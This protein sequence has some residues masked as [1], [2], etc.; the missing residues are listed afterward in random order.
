[1]K[2]IFVVLCFTICCFS[3]LMVWANKADENLTPF[4]NTLE[5]LS[6][7]TREALK[8]NRDSV[9]Y[10]A[11]EQIRI[12]RTINNL[13]AIHQG[14]S[15]LS[16]NEELNGSFETAIAYGDTAINVARLIKIPDKLAA[17]YNNMGLMQRSIANYKE[18]LEYLNKAL[19]IKKEMGDPLS[20]AFTLNN[21]GLTYFTLE[22]YD[23][24]LIYLT[25][26]L[27]LKWKY[28]TPL[29]MASTLT[30]I[31]AVY[32]ETFELDKA[33]EFYNQSIPLYIQNNEQEGLANVLLNIGLIYKIKAEY[34][35]ALKYYEEALSIS[36]ERD[37]PILEAKAQMFK[38]SIFLEQKN[39]TEAKRLFTLARTIF[40]S[41]DYR[42]GMAKVY[43]N[44]ALVYFEMGEYEDSRM[45]LNESANV[46]HIYS[47]K[48]ELAD[49]FLLMSKVDSIVGQFEE[50]LANFKTYVAYQ[51]SV[52]NKDSD[53][54]IERLK[55]EFETKIQHQKIVT[56]EK[57]Q[58]L[59]KIELNQQRLIVFTLIILF[60]FLLILSL[61]IIQRHRYQKRVAQKQREQES[62]I[63]QI[64]S[65]TLKNIIHY[66]NK[67][68]TTNVMH[69]IEKNE[70]IEQT[71]YSLNHW[72]STSKLN[73]SQKAE[74]DRIVSSMKSNTNKDFWK[75]FEKRFEAVYST[76]YESLDNKF[77][78]LSPNDRKL[79]AFLKLNMSTKEIAA[80]TLKGPHSINIA[81][82]RLRKKLGITN[83][84]TNIVTFLNNIDKPMTYN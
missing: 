14:Y 39:L 45:Y 27:A 78:E 25:Q 28:G 36:I 46:G 7:L 44:L 84:E 11:L 74:L 82:T 75:E 50:S 4:E 20:L 71:I 10:Y 24:S 29:Q 64:E 53:R 15:N 54:R 58:S 51:D 40:E 70:I 30:N 2:N 72:K 80:I 31:G 49:N 66:N 60:L 26:A 63:H 33:L 22:D 1:M 6:E 83:T 56:L 12:G 41:I 81:R 3:R 69:L 68:L 65:Q 79:C 9:R 5:N 73:E 47:T 59:K 57:D 21:I 19:L 61:F 32:N 16:R 76:F 55:I 23:K 8:T 77:P 34:K 52:H 17:A 18:A 42:V 35:L 38:G 13:S 37:F 48:L 62:K 67:T 43:Y